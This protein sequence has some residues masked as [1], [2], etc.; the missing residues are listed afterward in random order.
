MAAVMGYGLKYFF[1]NLCST[2][3]FLFCVVIGLPMTADVAC[4]KQTQTGIEIASSPNPVG[5]GARALGLG[6][7]IAVADDATAASWNPGGLIQL[8]TPEVCTVGAACHRIEDNTFGTHPE[9]SGIQTIFSSNLNY[10]SI[11]CPFTLLNRNM[12]LSLNYQHL[13]D[14]NREWDLPLT[15]TSVNYIIDNQIQFVQKGELSALGLAYAVQI[16]PTLSV[17]LTLNFWDDWLDQNGWNQ[18]YRQDGR[19]IYRGRP[20]VSR[21]SYQDDF[22]F[23]GFNANFGVMWNASPKLTLGA[24]L[25]TPFTADLQRRFAFQSFVHFPTAPAA[26]STNSYDFS[27]EET[28]DM[29]LSVG[30]GLA[31]RFSDALT[32]SADLYRTQWDDFVHTEGDGNQISPVSGKN[33]DESDIDPTHQ[34]RVG[35]EYLFIRNTCIIPLRG[36]LYYDPAPA[37]GSPDD[38]YGLSIGS[39]IAYKRFVFDMAYQ[40][41]FGRDVGHSLVQGKEF[42]QDIDQHTLYASVIFHF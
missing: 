42:S 14:F 24:V 21:V 19:G 10:F 12:I 23:S 1:G 41:R 31:Y 35:A 26:D 37:E 20:V 6:A 2:A 16:T 11:S 13:F 32:V 22:E 38:Y 39:G 17:G 15:E 34:V 33:I 8:E 18:A 28:L 7:F 9:A 27:Q 5:S 30:I 40:Y 4:S 25:K 3:G 36:G 29:P